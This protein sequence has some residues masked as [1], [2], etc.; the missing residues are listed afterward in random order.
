ME[1][2]YAINERGEREYNAQVFSDPQSLPQGPRC[3]NNCDENLEHFPETM[4]K[5]F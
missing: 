1:L 4:K 2:T 5:I 3:P